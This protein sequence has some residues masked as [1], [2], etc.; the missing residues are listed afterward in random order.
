MK[1]FKSLVE[2]EDV[3][4]VPSDKRHANPNGMYLPITKVGRK[5]VHV[6]DMK[7]ESWNND[8]YAIGLVVDWPHGTVFKTQEDYL[9]YLNWNNF[10]RDVSK[11]KLSRQQQYDILKIVNGALK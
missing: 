3:W 9:D 7:V 10:E 6:G 2:G 8:N 5:Y 11:L 4:Y 1:D